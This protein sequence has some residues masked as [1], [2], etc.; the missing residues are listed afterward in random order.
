M[1][2]SRL[3]DVV[4]DL[5][6]LAAA[7]LVMS[8]V[9]RYMD[10]RS[11]ERTRAQRRGRK[12]LRLRLQHGARSKELQLTEHEAEVAADVVVPDEVAVSFSD[13]GG[14]ADQAR[15]LRRAILLP[16]TRPR[17]FDGSRLLHTPKGVLLHGP[18]GTGKTMLARAIAREASFNFIALNPARLLSKWSVHARHATISH[19]VG[20]PSLGSNLAVTWR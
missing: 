12:Q 17:L 15:Q 20:R 18:P 19:D 9:L 14:L 11:V 8:R 16:L 4:I 13:I 7:A 3:L 2:R 10:P 5:T 1:T 6:A